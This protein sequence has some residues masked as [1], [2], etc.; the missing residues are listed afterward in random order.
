MSKSRKCL[1][2]LNVGTPD[3]PEKSD[4]RRYLTQF[5][6]DKR[7]I[8]LPWLGRKILVN[9]III[10]FRV[11]TSVKI[12]SELWAKHGRILDTLTQRLTMKLQKHF[13][14]D[15]AVKYAMRYGNP[16]MDKAFDEIKEEGYDEL[17]LFPLFPQY[18]MSTTQTCLEEAHRLIK[19]K[20]VKLR[21][22]IVP[23]FF[24]DELFVEGIA[25]QA[26][27]QFDIEAYDHILFSYH[28]LPNRHLRKAHKNIGYS[29]NTIEGC[30][31]EKRLE[32][33]KI[34]CYKA[35][36]YET[37]RLLAKEL[38]I[39]EK[40]YTVAFQSRLS[41]DWLKPF[42]DV[43]VTELAKQGAK[44][45]LV[46][47]P[48]FTIDCLETLNEIGEEYAE[49]FYKAGGKQLDLVPCLNDSDEMVKLADSLLKN[50]VSE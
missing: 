5:L 49:E 40:N 30:S 33:F 43:T 29:S 32:G 24:N 25:K 4:V 3:S 19:K 11:N 10:P 12:Y 41:K 20:G 16:S 39:S 27:T 6:N 35:E 42:S 8:D 13:E 38:N 17:I 37:S 7:V 14:G 48:S 44:K 31:C 47:T 22:E 18:A 23:S 45:A 2:L 50:V 1:L 15:L 21:T 36:C 46:F 26:K 34:G 9:G 28:G